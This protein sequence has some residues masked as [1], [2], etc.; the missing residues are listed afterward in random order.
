MSL[1]PTGNHHREL[2]FETRSGTLLAISKGDFIALDFPQNPPVQLV[3]EQHTRLQPLIDLCCGSLGPDSV[4][5][6]F[7]SKAT[8]KLLIRMK[9]SVTMSNLTNCIVLPDHFQAAC[10]DDDVKGVILTVRGSR[11][12]ECVDKDGI[13]FDFISRYFAPW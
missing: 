11:E 4:E 1:F 5:E 6:I 7:L 12:N 3:A 13:V 2:K 8:R 10:D 9:D